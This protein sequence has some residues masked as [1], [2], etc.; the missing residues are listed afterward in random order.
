MIK[1]ERLEKLISVLAIAFCLAHKAGE[2]LSE[3]HPIL[4]KNYKE[5]K[6]PQYSFFRYGLDFLRNLLLQPNQKIMQFKRVLS[7]FFSISAEK[8]AFL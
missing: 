8:E 1:P 4:L 6:R 5:S 7:Y 2:W 3:K